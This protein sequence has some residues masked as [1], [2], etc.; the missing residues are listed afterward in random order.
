MLIRDIESNLN[1]KSQKQYHEYVKSS[2]D[3]SMDG[4][5]TEEL[6]WSIRKIPVLDIMNKEAFPIS[7]EQWLQWI[8]DEQKERLN[9]WGYDIITQIEDYWL[10]EPEQEPLIIAET[11]EG[12]IEIWDGYHRFGI[13]I[14]NNLDTIPVIFG[15]KT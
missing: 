10:A 12:K 13:S 2:E 5:N 6:H 15:S 1:L 3:M 7:R 4:I 9:E 8:Q 11:K 14:R